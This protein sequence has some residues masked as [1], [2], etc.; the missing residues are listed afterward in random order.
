MGKSD[1]LSR[2]AGHE[3][4]ENDNVD[5]ILLKDELFINALTADTIDVDLLQ[6]IKKA[7]RQGKDRVVMKALAAKETDWEET[8][9]GLVYWKGMLYVP[10]NKE[11]RE[12]II[13]IHHDDPLA[14][15]PGRYKTQELITR[16]F[17]WPGMQREIRQY[18]TGCDSCQRTKSHHHR[19]HTQLQPNEIPSQPWEIIS[20]DL[21]GELPESRGFNA[22]CV[23]V[24]RFTKQIHALPTRMELNSEGLARI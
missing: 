5:I 9:A 7:M 11:L 3:R 13:R 10:R 23:I 12:D 8:E 1:L 16:D 19:P 18:I 2:R 17:W 6:K 20:V 22:I 24:D 15:H 21:I 4:G 14:G